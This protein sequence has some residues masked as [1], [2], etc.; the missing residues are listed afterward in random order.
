MCLDCCSIAI[1]VTASGWP[2]TSW[3]K[4]ETG[5]HGASLA[6]VRAPVVEEY[7]FA[8][9]AVIIQGR[10]LFTTACIKTN[11]TF[12]YCVTPDRGATYKNDLKMWMIKV[13]E[14]KHN[15]EQNIP[16]LS[17]LPLPQTAQ[18]RPEMRGGGFP[19]PDVQHQRVWG[20]LQRSKRRAV[21]RLGPSVWNLHQQAPLAALWTP[22]PWVCTCKQC[23]GVEIWTRQTLSDDILWKS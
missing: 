2:P 15:L 11:I 22:R 9:A 23:I 13:S 6:S 4:M 12:R 14:V 1:E 3:G 18:R 17:D 19:I 10:K 8:H 21:P 16:V 7:S 5:V 20:Y